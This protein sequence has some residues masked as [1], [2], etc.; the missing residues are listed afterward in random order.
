MSKSKSSDLACPTGPL[1]ARI[2]EAVIR[3]GGLPE[4]CRFLNTTAADHSINEFG[5]RI[6]NIGLARRNAFVVPVRYYDLCSHQEQ[7]EAGKFDWVT[8][9]DKDLILKNPAEHLYTLPIGEVKQRIIL[10]C[11]GRK[12]KKED[13]L[14][15]MI[16]LYVRPVLSPEFLALTRY[17]PDLQRRFPFIGLGSVWVDSVDC[18]GVLCACGNFGCRGLDLYR[19]NAVWGGGS[20]FPAVCLDI[21]S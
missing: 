14:A 13:V 17:H 9:Y 8:N 20:R 6:A 18:C 5:N 21:A 16:E 11:L 15:K 19:D 10:V 3:N 2:E 7:I 1:K 12:A 4:D